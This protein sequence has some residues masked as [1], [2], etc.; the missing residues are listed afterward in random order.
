MVIGT[1]WVS[2]IVGGVATGVALAGAWIP[3]YWRDERAT[4]QA[5]QHSWSDLWAFLESQD[6]VHAAY[7][8]LMHLWLAVFGTS[9]VAARLPSAL[10]VGICV[11]GVVKIGLI[12]VDLRC[13]VAAGFLMALLPVT[14]HYG[15][16]AR[17]Y[18]ITCAL[19]T[20]S[21]FL[22]IRASRSNG[23]GWWLGY[24]ALLSAATAMFLYAMLIGLAHSLTLALAR[25]PL[26]RQL[27]SFFVA[28]L[29]ISPM[30][31]RAFD[32]SGQVSWISRV[33]AKNVLS[34]PL[35][36]VVSV[37]LPRPPS[38]PVYPTFVLTGAALLLA[39]TLWILAAWAALTLRSLRR[40]GEINLAQ[41]TIPTMA[42]PAALLVLVSVL[43]PT[44]VARYIFFSAPAFALIVGYALSRLMTSMLLGCVVLM[45]AL[46]LPL[47]LADRQPL[48]KSRV[49][50]IG[51]S[52][53][54][55]PVCCD[56]NH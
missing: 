7:Y 25:K 51:A 19:V 53:T 37:P 34:A 49:I 41:L 56:R 14:S 3:R 43:Q 39:V 24:A 52:A 13:G 29:S 46:A 16:E 23:W 55:N 21:H 12:L 47:W 35:A 8:A 42:L 54:G 26:Q 44:F 18:A 33:L 28:L 17:P 27:L 50:S 32:Q 1:R 10:A 2:I 5:A 22:L 15:M 31:V 45:L 11:V 4:L 48:S 6:V 36:W 40:A 38:L 30:A 20:W 9:E